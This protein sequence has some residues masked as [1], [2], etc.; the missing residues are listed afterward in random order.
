MQSSGGTPRCG[1]SF[2]RTLGLARLKQ[3][4]PALF[5]ALNDAAICNRPLLKFPIDSTSNGYS[6]LFLHEGSE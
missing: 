1:Y 3:S 6:S 5:A 2:R 4:F